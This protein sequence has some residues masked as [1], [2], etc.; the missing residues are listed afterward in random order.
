MPQLRTK[1]SERTAT[2]RF[3]RARAALDYLPPKQAAEAHAFAVHLARLLTASEFRDKIE[4]DGFEPAFVAAIN[5]DNVEEIL[6]EM[7]EGD[8]VLDD[9]ATHK[10]FQDLLDKHREA[11]GNMEKIFGEERP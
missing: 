8:E 10:A 9:A 1:L 7:V 4:A 6:A 5:A 3:A 11:L 2:K